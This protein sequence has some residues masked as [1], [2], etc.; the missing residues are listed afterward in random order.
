[1]RGDELGVRD[2]HKRAGDG[3]VDSALLL[4]L[5]ASNAQCR[6][7][8][9]AGS[10]HAPAVDAKATERTW[11]GRERVNCDGIDE[12]CGMG[13]RDNFRVLFLFTYVYC[14]RV[15]RL[16]SY[17][18]RDTVLQKKLDAYKNASA[19]SSTLSTDSLLRRRLLSLVRI[20]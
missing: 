6:L 4:R 14:S 5:L 3:A 12:S 8:Y 2:E 20:H 19:I 1:M 10:P 15:I 11:C 7:Q 13:A 16:Q 17:P 9:T 18:A